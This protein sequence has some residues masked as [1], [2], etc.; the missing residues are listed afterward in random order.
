MLVLTSCIE[1]VEEITV[2][3]DQSGTISYS[4]KTDQLT[5]LFSSLP[6]LF[7]QNTLKEEM[8]KR[9]EKFATKFKNNKGIKNVQFIMGDN[10]T[11]AS[12]SFDFNN[13]KE[14]NIAM[15]EIAGS[16]KTFFAPSYLK[17]GKHKLKKFNIA[18]YLKKK[19]V[20]QDIILPDEF[21]DMIELRTVY[22]LPGNI[23]SAK[24]KSVIMAEDRKSIVQK[25]EFT[26]VYD[27]K[28]NTG[29]KIRY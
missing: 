7:D 14:L 19:L 13:T 23:K 10:I 11:D 20:E 27:N 12:L 25:F 8:T 4:I 22:N 18:P 26:D 21:M 9:F 17:I 2:N 6:G 24:G 16:K 1:I 29:I 15:Y 28:I 5:S 3:P